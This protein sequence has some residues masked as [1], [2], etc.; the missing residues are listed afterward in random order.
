MRMRLRRLPAPQLE[1]RAGV[2]TRPACHAS[3]SS[4]QHRALLPES[5]SPISQ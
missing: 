5:G 3:P 1:G 2:S 4:V